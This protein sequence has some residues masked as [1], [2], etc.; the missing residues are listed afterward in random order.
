MANFQ[1]GSYKPPI[2]QEFH[3]PWY[4][5]CTFVAISNAYLNLVHNSCTAPFLWSR[6]SIFCFCFPDWPYGRFYGAH[7]IYGNKWKSRREKYLLICLRSVRNPWAV[8]N[9]PVLR[10]YAMYYIWAVPLIPLRVPA[11]VCVSLAREIHQ[12]NFLSQV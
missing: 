1:I 8:A 11:I 10:A 2:N 6:N 3:P 5:E 4:A 9:E 12:S 7:N